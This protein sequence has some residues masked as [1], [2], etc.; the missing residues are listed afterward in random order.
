[1]SVELFFVNYTGTGDLV[2]RAVSG[3]LIGGGGVFYLCAY[4][5]PTYSAPS[6]MSRKPHLQPC[7]QSQRGGSQFP[8]T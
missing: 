7:S 6:L 5:P 3:G 1:M 2:G 4:L 8:T